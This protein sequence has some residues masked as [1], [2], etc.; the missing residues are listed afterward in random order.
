MSKKSSLR[1][2][3]Y[4]VE[5]GLKKETIKEFGL[6]YCKRRLLKGRII[7]PIHNEKGELIAYAGRYPGDPP[8][9][10]SKY[11]FP[12]NFKKSY[13][14]FNLNRVRN[15]DKERELIL[16]EGF[17]NVFNLWQNGFRNTA[18]LMGTSI[19]KEQEELIVEYLGKNGKLT[20]IFD[21]DE[22]G[23]NA[24]REAIERL[25]ERVYIK[26]VR[27]ENGVD[28]GRISKKEINNLL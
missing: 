19:S 26:I 18:A 8:E 12:P 28:L 11:I 23:E 4:L 6:G 9:G 3:L 10:E 27:L 20:L 13:V 15:S 16:V 17:F 7:I 21:P 25:T 14:I 5:R 2:E 24:E 22:A 1:K